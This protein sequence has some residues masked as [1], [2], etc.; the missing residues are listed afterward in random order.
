MPKMKSKG[1]V[2]KRF[3]TTKSGKLKSSRPHRGH[4]HAIKDAKHKRGKRSALVTE[5]TWARLLM[6]M[7]GG[8]R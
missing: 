7:L 4:M 8:G 5:G 1:A 6:R 3:R 2:K